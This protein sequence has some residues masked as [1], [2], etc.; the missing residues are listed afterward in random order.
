M[1]LTMLLQSLG[2]E[3]EVATRGRE[4]IDI[5]AA[6]DFDVLLL[7]IAMPGADGIKALE[8]SRALDAARGRVTPPAIA[9][10]ANSMPAQVKRYL[11][12]EFAGHVPKPIDT[13]VLDRVIQNH[14]AGLAEAPDAA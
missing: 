12:A 6:R 9:V 8:A 5:C 3:P 2:I 1:V 4:A 10:T 7:D 13:D 14:A 11:E